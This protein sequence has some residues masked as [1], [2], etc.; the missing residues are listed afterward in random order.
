LFFGTINLK[1]AL[2]SAVLGEGIVHKIETLKNS[3]PLCG[4]DLKGDNSVKYFCLGC[5]MLFDKYSLNT[6]KSIYAKII[7]GIKLY[8]HNAGTSKAVV[9]VSG[10][11]DSAVV[12][13]LLV[14]ALGK[15]NVAGFLLPETGLTKKES[16]E[17]GEDLCRHLKVKSYIIPIDSILSEF[18]NAGFKLGSIA[19]ANT[20]ARIRSSLLYAYANTSNALVVGTGN[21]TELMMG[22][23]TKYG[24]GASDI[25]P[26]GDL[27]KRQVIELAQFLK[28]PDRII[29]R[30]PTAE[31][32]P[33]Q[34][35][36]GELGAKYADIDNVL[37][38]I[39]DG[40]EI[41]GELADRIKKRIKLTEHKRQLPA[42]IKVC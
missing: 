35:D 34:T 37:E 15:D 7:K 32:L 29:N 3:C 6:M 28:I 25:L 26:I 12:L 24:D 27:L 18:K 22:Y 11:I 38:K 41:T 42:I 4:G 16:T 13:K 9:G 14:D 30:T 19:L 39:C 2:S 40:R 33:G 5:F 31:L 20:K 10:G 23:F 36:E 17:Y 1:I 21:K 8:F